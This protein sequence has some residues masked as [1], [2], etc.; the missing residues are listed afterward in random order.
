VSTNK[1]GGGSFEST[2]KSEFDRVFQQ[3]YLLDNR[4]SQIEFETL[5]DFMGDLAGK[6]VLDL[7]CGIGRTSMRLAPHAGEVIGYDISPVAVD[8]ANENARR[9][10]LGNFRAELNNFSEVQ[11]G[12]FDVVLC[13]NMLHHTIDP[14]AVL[15]SIHT[16]LRPGGELVILENNPVNPLFPFYFVM[17]GQVRA[18]LTR[19]YLMVNRFTLERALRE[20]GF[21]IDALKRHGFLPTMLYNYSLAFKSINEALNRIPVVNELAAFH[22]IRARKRGLR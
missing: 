17:I 13:V 19:Q 3:A 16:A 7:G 10:G 14:R 21:E 4:A 5:L 8:K 6:R 12:S 2:Q 1:H 20:A 11:P 15:A 18:H 22:F 9:L